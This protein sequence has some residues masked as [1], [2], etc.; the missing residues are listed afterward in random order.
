MS[1]LNKFAQRLKRRRGGR[2]TSAIADATPLMPVPAAQSLVIPDSTKRL[3]EG[4]VVETSLLARV[5]GIK[6][7]TVQGTVLVSPARLEEQDGHSEVA[8]VWS[9]AGMAGGSSQ[10]GSAVGTR[11]RI[12]AH[13]LDE[14]ASH[15]RDL[16]TPSSSAESHC[17]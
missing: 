8:P 4:V 5:L 16:S 11:L 7:L 17:D 6:L 3:S 2:H 10:S 14:N 13:L 15:L 12:T 1:L 9:P